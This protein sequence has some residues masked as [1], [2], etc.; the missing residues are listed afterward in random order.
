MG[1]GGL[2]HDRQPETGPRQRTRAVR[3]EEALEHARQV[4]GFEARA[5][6]AHAER[7]V[8][9]LDLDR[10]ARRAPAARVVEQVRDRAADALGLAAD[11][12]GLDA[13]LERRGVA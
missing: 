2:A 10:A 4:A 12:G 5:V 11:D 8:A 13:R 9:Q 7:A 6:V 1:L 3:A